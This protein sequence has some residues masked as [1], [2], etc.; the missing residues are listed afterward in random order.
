MYNFLELLVWGRKSKTWRRW[1]YGRRIQRKQ[2]R[3]FNELAWVLYDWL[4]YVHGG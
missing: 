1:I 3:Q 4:D 2:R